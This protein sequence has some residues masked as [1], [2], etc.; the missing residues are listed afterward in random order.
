MISNF[1]S[2]KNLP[3][4]VRII[5]LLLFV[6]AIFNLINSMISIF[7]DLSL[8]HFQP[9]VFIPAIL[10]LIVSLGMAFIYIFLAFG[11]WKG[12][13][14][15]KIATI[16]FIVL[17]LLLTLL[18]IHNITIK[19]LIFMVVQLVIGVYLLLSKQVKFTFK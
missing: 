10:G 6:L 7:K 1:K 11:L 3:V 12:K 5:S 17:L 19:S 16:I 13:K 14:W 2:V 4:P 18:N 15:A 9:L 8:Y